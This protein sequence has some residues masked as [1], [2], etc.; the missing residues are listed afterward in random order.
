M[1]KEACLGHLQLIRSPSTQNK[2]LVDSEDSP[3]LRLLKH[4]ALR[5]LP[6]HFG[7]LMRRSVWFMQK[8]LCFGLFLAVLGLELRPLPM[9][10][11]H[12]ASEPYLTPS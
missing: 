3:R 9:L 8:R 11:K 7:I 5:A 4:S 12:F 1:K 2:P 6:G 10:G